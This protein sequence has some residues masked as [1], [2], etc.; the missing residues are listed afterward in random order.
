MGAA[1]TTTK[2]CVGYGAGLLL[3]S[4]PAARPSATQPWSLMREGMHSRME[5]PPPESH[6]GVGGGRHI[7]PTRLGV[8]LFAGVATIA[9]GEVSCAHLLLSVRLAT[10]AGQSSVCAQQIGVKACCRIG[11]RG[12][13]ARRLRSASG[14]S[15]AQQHSVLPAA[16]CNSQIYTNS[17]RCQL[18][19][20]WFLRHGLS[21]VSCP[22][23]SPF[24][25]LAGRG[26]SRKRCHLQGRASSR[27]LCGAEPLQRHI[28]DTQREARRLV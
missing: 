4:P 25:Y 24:R 27:R 1:V 23:R 28:A 19:A 26:Q 22:I 12:L 21:A 9:G 13:S 2:A 6:A 17:K 5:A 18:L 20:D 15:R 3:R 16:A 7:L 8:F 14:V 11:W 10:S